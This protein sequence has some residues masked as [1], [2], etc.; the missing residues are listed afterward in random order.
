M[1]KGGVQHLKVAPSGSV[2]LLAPYTGNAGQLD[3]GQGLAA[4]TGMAWE[5]FV[6]AS[7]LGF[8]E[9]SRLGAGKHPLPVGSYSLYEGRLQGKGL[10]ARVEFPGQ[11]L[12]EIKAEQAATLPAFGAPLKVGAKVALGG[13][14][15]EVAEIRITGKG[16]EIYWPL[17]ENC[18][19]ISVLEK[20]QK[21]RQETTVWRAEGTWKDQTVEWS[22]DG[23]YDVQ[24]SYG[25]ATWGNLTSENYPIQKG[26]K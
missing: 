26:G 6:L 2:A 19:T 23:N 13:L 18:P 5:F 9:L 10:S 8:F 3:L 22:K 17:H 15:I 1:A 25:N 24:I 7:P 14:G 4:P 21:V 11:A 20:G 12:V 16:G